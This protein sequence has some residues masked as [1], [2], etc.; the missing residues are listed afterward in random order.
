MKSETPPLFAG[1]CIRTYTGIYIDLLDPSPEDIR[2][3]DIAHALAQVPRFAGHLKHPYSVA[4]HSIFCS[5]LA[6][7]EL[8][9]QALL[10]DASEAYISDIPSPIKK[11]LTSYKI[12]ERRLMD[13]IEERFNLGLWVATHPDIK[14]I[15]AKAL[16]W[17][18]D[19]LAVKRYD[20]SAPPQQVE[21]NFLKT[22]QTLY[23]D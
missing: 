10:H 18:W 1:N 16:N 12:I 15:D 19:L 20:L 14:R 4:Q 6:P 8:K 7:P 23:N 21:R 3:E 17:E 9:L 11:H 2:I 22:F 13:A 5:R